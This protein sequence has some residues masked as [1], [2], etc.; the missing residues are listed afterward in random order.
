MSESLPPQLLAPQTPGWTPPPPQRAEGR[1]GLATAS[2]TFGIVAL[3]LNVLLIPTILAIVFGAVALGRGAAGRTR[4]IVGIV[5]GGVGVIALGIQLAIAIPVFI[6]AQQ[7]A[8]GRSV[9]SSIS[10]GLAQQGT[11]VTS[12][13]CPT[14]VTL[15]AGATTACTAVSQSGAALRIDV[16]FTDARGGFT[17]RVSPF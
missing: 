14:P 8:V 17:Y 10:S 9:E 12:V 4:S 11:V 3:V 15:R 7:A 13:D 6:G 5:L 2:L 16:T 1:T